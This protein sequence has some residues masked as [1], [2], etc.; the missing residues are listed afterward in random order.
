M[1]VE[2]GRHGD[3]LLQDQKVQH[4][5]GPDTQMT[6]ST[7]QAMATA[8]EVPKISVQE[9]KAQSKSQRRWTYIVMVV[10]ITAMVM[11]IISMAWEGSAVA[12]IAFL[13]PLVGGP[14]VIY[15]RKILNKLPTLT[16]VI[17]QTRE[18]VNR[19]TI[20]N[21][22]FSQEND[23]LEVEVGELKEL[24][25]KFYTI[26]KKSGT[27]VEEMKNLIKENGEIQ[28]Q[29]R[30]ILDAQQLQD[31]FSAIVRSDT[32]QD[33][34]LTDEEL[35]RCMLRLKGYNVVDKERLKD[36]LRLWAG[37]WESEEWKKLEKENSLWAL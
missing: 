14:Y 9:G 1:D 28:K 31:I 24:D 36:T 34:Q 26:C 37:K 19:L 16:N 30:K 32:N 35:D 25:H 5:A 20:Q 29:M 6:T 22:R 2:E 18:Q 10:A 23:R 13:F 27:N 3:P 7:V 21:N 33:F 11:G 8:A 15:Q 12:I 4:R 17:N